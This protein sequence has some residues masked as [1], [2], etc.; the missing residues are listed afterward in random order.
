MHAEN[1]RKKKYDLTQTIAGER[2]RGDPDGDLP[3]ATTPAEKKREIFQKKGRRGK[4]H[5]Q[6]AQRKA[7]LKGENAAEGEATKFKILGDDAPRTDD[8]KNDK[9][10]DGV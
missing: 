9:I 1:Q 10:R 3:H 8:S 6:D 2:D 7:A 4:F 5:K